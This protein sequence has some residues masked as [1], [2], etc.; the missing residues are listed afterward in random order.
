MN[1]VF[2]TNQIDLNPPITWGELQPH[3]TGSGSR[4]DSVPYHYL[5]GDALVVGDLML[6]IAMIATPGPGDTERHRLIAESIQ[7]ASDE[8]VPGLRLNQTLAQI[9]T[10]FS[11]APDGTV[12][13]FTG[14]L[15]C[16][17]PPAYPWFLYALNG[18]VITLRH[19]SASFNDSTEPTAPDRVTDRLYVEVVEHTRYWLPVTPDDTSDWDSIA[20]AA[21]VD[22]T[23]SALSEQ[24]SDDLHAIAADHPVAAEIFV[25]TEREFGAI[26]TTKP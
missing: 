1:H 18:E 9:V 16:Q 4:P 25:G 15:E 3:L 20:A 5:G 11:T 21:G 8:A 26:T 17:A 23:E 7:G 12:R 13:T 2:I 19:Q 22:D 10:D 14:H 24:A 6:T